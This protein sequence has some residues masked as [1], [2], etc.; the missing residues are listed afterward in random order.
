MDGWREIVNESG[1]RFH[2]STIQLVLVFRLKLVIL[3]NNIFRRMGF[4]AD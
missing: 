3:S 2:S 4:N 1:T